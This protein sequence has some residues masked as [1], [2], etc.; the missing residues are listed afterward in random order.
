MR[1]VAGKQKEVIT[2][3]DAKG[4]LI[5]KMISPLMVEF[6][7]RDLVQVMVGASI[8]AIPVGFTQEVWDLGANLPLSRVLSIGLLS[9]FFIS[10]F[11]YYNYYRVHFRQHWDEFLKRVLTTYLLSILIVA[12]ILTLIQVTPWQADFVVALKRVILVAFPAS[13]SAAI[14][15]MLK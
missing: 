14:A 3:S 13:M 12:L 1:Q 4:N 15:D 9:L 2:V 7:P 10:V 6:Y 8:L 11:V 5:H